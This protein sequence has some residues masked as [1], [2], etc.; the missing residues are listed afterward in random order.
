MELTFILVLIY[1]GV[2]KNYI[3]YLLK[4]FLK[5]GEMGQ[6]NF[7]KCQSFI[8]FKC[9]LSLYLELTDTG[10]LIRKIKIEAGRRRDYENPWLRSEEKKD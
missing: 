8:F 5:F 9:F 2:E 3:F 6:T 7:D 4:F 10:H 1:T